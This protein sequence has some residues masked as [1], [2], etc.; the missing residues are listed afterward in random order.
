MTTLSSSERFSALAAKLKAQR[1]LEGDRKQRLAEIKP[2]FKSRT[3]N[4]GDLT[5]S[6]RTDRLRIAKLKDDALWQ[7]DAILV[8]GQHQLCNCCGFEAKAT[9]GFFLRQ[10][11]S[12]INGARR[13][14]GIG[15]IPEGLP[16]ES[17]VKGVL[18]PRCVQCT[19]RNS[20]TD[21]LLVA[22]VEDATPGL[23]NQLQLQL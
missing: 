20:T 1:Q 6:E 22:L 23:D 5:G 10:H 21:D 9:S 18:L 3:F 2:S 17:S 19:D 7:T 4:L 14:Q 15:Y 11:H 8:V 13:L 16:I 12:I